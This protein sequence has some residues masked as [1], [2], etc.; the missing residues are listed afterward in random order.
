MRA[1]RAMTSRE[2]GASPDAASSP[3]PPEKSRGSPAGRSGWPGGRFARSRRGSVAVI[4]A[5]TLPV[6]IGFVGLAIEVGM[7]LL[8]K[9]AMQG[10][11]DAAAYSAAI[12][13]AVGDVPYVTEGTAVAAQDGY[14]NGAN[15]IVVTVNNPPQYGNY[16]SDSSA[17]EVIIRQ[18][19]PLLLSAFLPG[20]TA[21]TISARAAA[22]EPEGACII[23]LS[24]TGTGVSLSGGTSVSAPG[25]A[26]ASNQTINQANCGVTITT[27]DAAYNTA[28]PGAGSGC[29]T[30]IEPPAGTPA[31]TF[32][33]Q[34]TPDPL[35]TAAGVVAAT[36]R[37][38]SVAALTSPAS[39][40]L[41]SGGDITFGYTQST[42]ESQ[43]TADGC[44]G[45]F[46][47]S[48]WTVICSGNGP[49]YFGNIGLAGGITVNFNTGGSASAVYNFNGITNTGT[50]LNF[51]PGTFNIAQGIYIT[52]GGSATSFG[53]GTFNIGRVSG[54]TVCSGAPSPGGGFSI[55]MNGSSLVFG[56]PST[57][58]L[59]GGIWNKGGGTLTLGS[60]STN[61]FDIG[62]AAD[63]YSLYVGGGAQTT[64][65]DATG[66]G[67]LF[68][69]AG[70]I[71][72]SGGSCLWI[73]TAAQHDINGFIALQG[74]LTMGAGVYTVT[75][76]IDIGGSGGGDVSCNGVSVGV[77]G[78]DVTLV[79]GGKK[80]DSNC[81]G[82]T[83]C[84][85][86]GFSN[87][88][89]TAPTSGVTESLAVIGPTSSKITAGASLIEGA[90]NTSISGAF[91][92]PDGP[93]SLGGGASIGSGPGQ[94]LELIGSQVTLS[95][96]ATAASLCKSLPTTLVGGQI[97]E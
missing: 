2:A 10:A 16:T 26:V 40:P 91:Y 24:N 12:A 37:L 46:S 35:A 54:A 87:V 80:I 55:C 29:S 82:V 42:T 1:M 83:F 71:A 85:G 57:F 61:S 94:C 64:F 75:D 31:V 25:C 44:T 93:I 21:P 60:G 41:S 49:F 27:K 90:S 20:V 43:I 30:F 28:M 84:I 52:G 8:V 74:G 65:A 6:M 79:I 13:A 9:R 45:S 15:G 96:G 97:V 11:A 69:T 56:G 22:I 39:P 38:S 95:G 78:D 86:S 92:Y 81:G 51:G 47:G 89:I 18:P 72:S 33:Q 14:A 53:A 70:S 62:V 58:V 73:S 67:D 17:V 63:G 68:E 7:W 77:L 36:G 50:A 32:V 34:V 76:Y 3:S 19:Q 5:I 88:T 48:T 66:S 23:A 4:F 59:A